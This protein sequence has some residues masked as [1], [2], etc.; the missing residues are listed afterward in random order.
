MAYRVGKRH[1]LRASVG[2]LLG[3]AVGFYN[4]S[5]PDRVF[6]TVAVAMIGLLVALVLGVLFDV[7]SV[8]L[9]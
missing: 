4:T 3:A 8:K 1:L 5:P 9:F 6:F 2:A 7:L